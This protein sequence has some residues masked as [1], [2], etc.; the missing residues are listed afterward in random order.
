MKIATISY[1]GSVGKTTLAKHLLAPRLSGTQIVSVETIN[2]DDSIKD[3]IKGHEYGSLI[4]ILQISDEIIIDVGASNVEEFMKRMASYRGSHEFFD[5]FV[6]PTTPDKKQQRDTIA[7]IK[8]LADAGVRPENIVL[9]MN[10]NNPDVRLDAAFEMVFRFHADFALFTL[11]LELVVD[12]ND[13]YQAIQGSPVTITDLVMD[14]T[15]YKAKI[16]D[17][18]TTETKLKYARSN[19]QKQLAQG[20]YENHDRV[21]AAMFPEVPVGEVVAA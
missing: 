19:A 2:K 4:E 14:T 1:A 3:P 6:V 17:A 18:K 11:N 5:H 20:V 15:D 7:T 8:A 21:F 16:R 9:I 13:I 12:E 10:K